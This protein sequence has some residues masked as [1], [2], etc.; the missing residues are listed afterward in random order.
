LHNAGQAAQSVWRLNPFQ[1]GV[2]IENMLGRSPQ[3]A[4]NFPVID[5]FQ[6]GVATSIKSIDL[7]AKS[8]QD[9]GVLTRTV[10]G[11]V[12][13][14]ATCQ[15]ATWANVTIN[16]NQITARELLLAIPS[17]ATAAQLAALQQLQAS[18]PNLGVTLNTVVI[19]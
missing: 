1:R 12:S 14:L 17:G 13:D 5:R 9:I 11:Y 10:Q 3:L 2:A 15:G 6:N 4:Q 8:Y 19:P 18:A 16:A 7:G